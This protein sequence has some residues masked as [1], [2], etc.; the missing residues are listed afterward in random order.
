MDLDLAQVRAFVATAER[1]HFGRAASELFLTQQAISKRIQRLEQKLGVQLLVRGTRDVT[2]T[3]AGQRFLPHARDLLATSASAVATARSPARPLRLD[4]WGHAQAP[5]RA[6][7]RLLTTTP[8]LTIE[9]SM[10]RNLDAAIQAIG[11]DEIDA[12]FGLVHLD[13][14]LPAGLT[15]RA[16]LLERLAVA[17]GTGHP[18]AGASEL[19]ATDL[20]GFPLWIPAGSAP[21]VLAG[22]QQFAGHLGV[23]LDTSGHNLGLEHAVQEIRRRPDVFTLLGRDWVIPAAE[24]VRLISLKPAPCSVWSLVWQESNQHPLLGLLLE[25]AA[26]TGRSEGWLAYDPRHD[27][28]PEAVLGVLR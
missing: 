7:R 9:P 11:R 21:E 22:Y 4:V 8:E 2:L 27:W 26:Q 6:V 24:G 28:L 12:C 17:V 15:H 5:L 10:R 19:T 13:R 14:P 25:S 20:N 16:V 18:L 1:L 3:E 23:T